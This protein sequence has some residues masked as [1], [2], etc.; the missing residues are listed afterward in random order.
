MP[1]TDWRARPLVTKAFPGTG[2]AS[3]GAQ[4]AIRAGRKAIAILTPLEGS[5]H[6]AA[7]L[8]TRASR[9]GHGFRGNDVDNFVKGR[10][11]TMT[12]MIVPAPSIPSETT[13]SQ[14]VQTIAQQAS[15]YLDALTRYVWICVA[16]F[17]ASS[18]GNGPFSGLPSTYSITR[19]SDR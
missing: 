5:R 14:D 2:C 7:I 1:T 18:T 13:A 16:S 17:L 11:I 6:S 15:V 8:E 19:S 12:M 4:R 3:L 9:D 10:S